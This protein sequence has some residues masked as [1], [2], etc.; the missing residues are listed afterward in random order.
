MKSLQQPVDKSVFPLMVV[1][2]QAPR[3]GS[4]CWLRAPI[5]RR[6]CRFGSNLGQQI[7]FVDCESSQRWTT[8]VANL[9]GIGG[10]FL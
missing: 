10:I 9:S 8:P 5:D 1:L 4:R 7:T 2:V 6:F 3:L